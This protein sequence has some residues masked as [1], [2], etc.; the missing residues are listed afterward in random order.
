RR[1]LR[2]LDAVQAEAA[3]ATQ[4]ILNAPA[5]IGNASRVHLDL[6]LRRIGSGAGSR[7]VV[8]YPAES[9]KNS[10][11]LSYELSPETIR[12]LDRYLTMVR[13][14]VLRDRSNRWLFPGEGSGPKGR[15]L[16]SSQIADFTE[17]HVGIRLTAHRLRPAA[18]YI[19]LRRTNNDVL[20]VQRLLG[21][22]DLKT[23][24]KY[25][26]HMSQDEATRAYD[27]TL[28]L[29]REELAP[30]LHAPVKRT[31]RKRIQPDEPT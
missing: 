31:R 16:L 27:E 1:P 30:L 25:Y 21:H 4:F 26:I 18:G 8:E 24:E 10:I 20:T 11:D 6:N 15:G 17:R 19:H 29:T 28:R 3:F 7:I 23:T 22:T 12:M 2:R 13:P 14:K 9:G 5:R